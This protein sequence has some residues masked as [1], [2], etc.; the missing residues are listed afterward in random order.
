MSFILIGGKFIGDD[1]VII[2]KIFNL[3]NLIKSG[4]LCEREAVS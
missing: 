2:T 3:Y 4:T 1:Q